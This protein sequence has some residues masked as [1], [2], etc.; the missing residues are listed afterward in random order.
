MLGLK[1][2]SITSFPPIHISFI[3]TWSNKNYL[4][5]AAVFSDKKAKF[6]DQVRHPSVLKGLQWFLV[7]SRI[8]LKFPNTVIVSFMNYAEYSQLSAHILL[9]TIFEFV[10][11]ILCNLTTMYY[12]DYFLFVFFLTM[13]GAICSPAFIYSLLLPEGQSFIHLGT[14]LSSIKTTFLSLSCGWECPFHVTKC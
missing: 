13:G 7:A 12:H 11:S 6:C 3:Y 10:F 2:L 8:K 14:W 9:H 5:L 4:P 1:Q